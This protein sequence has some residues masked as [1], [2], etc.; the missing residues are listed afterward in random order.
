VGD[1]LPNKEFWRPNGLYDPLPALRAFQGP[2]LAVFGARDTTKDV[3]A[4]TRLMRAAFEKGGNPRATVLVIPDA[5]HGLFETHT[6]LPL[7]RELPSLTRMAPGYLDALSEWIRE[8]IR[9][10]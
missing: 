6:G 5:N 10:R 9:P 8:G 7:E 2:V 3:D 1:K 4:N